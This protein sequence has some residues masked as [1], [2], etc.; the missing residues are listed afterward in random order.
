MN[1]IDIIEYF[2][3]ELQSPSN[4]FKYSETCNQDT[5]IICYDNFDKN[6]IIYELVCKHIFHKN[7]ILKWSK[8]NDL[9]PICK[10]KL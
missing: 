8:Y 6:T 9:C 10:E 4:V 3:K 1:D 2:I 7:C 5:C